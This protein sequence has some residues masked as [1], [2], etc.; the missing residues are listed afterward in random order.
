M[1]VDGLQ[2]VAVIDDDAVAVNTERRRPHY[3]AVVGGD[4]RSVRRHGQ[5]ESQMNLSIDFLPLVNVSA[6]VGEFRFHL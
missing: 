1:T 5:V 6:N 4:N 2:T 3:F